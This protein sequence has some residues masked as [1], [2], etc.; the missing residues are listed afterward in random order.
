MSRGVCYRCVLPRVCAMDTC[1]YLA[2]LASGYLIMYRERGQEVW[3]VA[4]S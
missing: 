2:L 3:Y 4:V 1:M